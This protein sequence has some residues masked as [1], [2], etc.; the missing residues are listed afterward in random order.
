MQGAGLAMGRP[1]AH[2][3]GGAIENPSSVVS[4]RRR[5]TRYVPPRLAMGGG[6]S[7]QGMPPFSKAE[8]SGYADGEREAAASMTDTYEPLAAVPWFSPELPKT[9]TDSR[10]TDIIQRTAKAYNRYKALL[11]VAEAEYIRRYGCA[12]GDH[13]DD[14]W[15]DSLHGACGEADEYL[16]AARVH[17]N[18]STR[19]G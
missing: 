1:K 6:A 5:R 4:D 7:N 13:D 2:D 12:P 19:I 3:H 16:T 14:F 18:A 9:M 17:E 10:F 8:H 15:I 11:D